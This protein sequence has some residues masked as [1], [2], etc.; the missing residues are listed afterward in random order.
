M[1][2]WMAGSMARWMNGRM[3]SCLEGWLAGW[4]D[5]N[6][7]FLLIDHLLRN[8]FEPHNALV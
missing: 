1:D 4:M 3:A 8:D 6:S 5:G 7:R 2:G